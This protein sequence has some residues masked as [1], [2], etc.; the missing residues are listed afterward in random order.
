MGSLRGKS[1]SEQTLGVSQ[2]D[3]KTRPGVP[4]L[5]HSQVHGNTEQWT[6]GLCLSLGELLQGR[7]G[8][9]T[10]CPA[11]GEAGWL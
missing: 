8:P 11:P 9:A 10:P 3:L 5:P 6:A 4:Q 2:S 1:N 7:V